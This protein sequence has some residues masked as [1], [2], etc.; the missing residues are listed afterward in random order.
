MTRSRLVLFVSVVI[1]ALGAVAGLGVLWLDSA[2]ADVGPLPGRG[3]VLPA[4]TR[5]VAGVDVKRF[6]A[7]PMFARYTAREGMHPKAMRDLEEKT[8]LDPARDIDQIVVAGSREGG[9]KA[10]PLVLALGRFDLGR[11]G[12]TLKKA[13][14]A[15]ERTH[16]GVKLFSFADESGA[17]SVAL[18]DE[19]ALVF[20]PT[21]RVEEVAASHAR[22]EA[23]LGENAE[24]LALVESVKP[25]STFWL[26]GDKTAMAALPSA[27]PGQGGTAAMNLPPL[28]SLTLVGDLDP[29]LSLALTGITADE[30]AATKLADVVRGFVALLS[31]QASQ[32]P[33]LQQLASAFSVTTEANRVRVS[34]RISYEV[35]D[36]LQPKKK[37]VAAEAEEREAESEGT[38]T[39]TPPE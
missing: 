6:T 29:Q 20:G 34:A 26:V 15:N 4:E 12:Q 16:S 28:Q 10:R 19:E 25:G 39:V 1:V 14:K 5:F 21:D 8:G 32:K 38:A 13:A 2:R 37:D 35:L 23:P 36:A 33:E 31:L 9:P 11:I 18:L 22:G 7:S 17:S 24:M 27:I 3:L 30:T